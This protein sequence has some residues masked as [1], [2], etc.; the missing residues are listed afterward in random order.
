M[1]RVL[2]LHLNCAVNIFSLLITVT[3]SET[4]CGKYNDLLILPKDYNYRLPPTDN[5][6]VTNDIQL[7]SI[8]QVN[9]L[10]QSKVLQWEK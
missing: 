2:T 8:I 4:L 5:V 1:C 10:A 7:I 6:P 9:F 3:A